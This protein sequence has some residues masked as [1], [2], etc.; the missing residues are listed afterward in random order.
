MVHKV[1]IKKKEII[2]KLE[3]LLTSWTLNFV[4]P[5]RWHRILE[6]NN[7]GGLNM[8]HQKYCK[9]ICRKICLRYRL[10]FIIKSCHYKSMWR[11]DILNSI[12]LVVTKNKY[13]MSKGY[14]T[15]EKKTWNKFY[16]FIKSTPM[17]KSL[18]ILI[19]K[20]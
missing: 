17:C 9:Q 11:I 3:G 15:A 4:W 14:R 8:L 1:H 10:E 18:N 13:I 5:Q 7:W 19:L 2:L 6:C 20:T 16:V 12:R